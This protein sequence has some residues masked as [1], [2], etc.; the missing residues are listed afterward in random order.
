MLIL[1]IALKGKMFKLP[2]T[3]QISDE[4]MYNILSA[5]DKHQISDKHMYDILSAQDK[6]Q[7]SDE[8]MY[9]ILSAQDKHLISHLMS[10]EHRSI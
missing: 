5:Q 7:I 3:H 1:T 6:H 4:H 2:I 8:H 10:D 9:D